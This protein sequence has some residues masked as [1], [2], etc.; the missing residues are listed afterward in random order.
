M[1]QQWNLKSWMQRANIGWT[2]SSLGIQ[3]LPT[4]SLQ[5][6]FAKFALIRYDGVLSTEV[7]VGMVCVRGYPNGQCVTLIY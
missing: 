6:W 2:R 5:A 4:G 1:F 3:M 7:R